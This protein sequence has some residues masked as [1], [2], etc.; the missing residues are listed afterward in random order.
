[1]V[2]TALIQTCIIDPQKTYMIRDSIETSGPQYGMQSFDMALL[3]LLADGS[4]TEE[5]ALAASS[6]PTAL[7][8]KLKGV[9]TP[10]DWRM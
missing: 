8:L 1:M 4:I 3:R 5:T 10:S 7:Q 2:H 9:E 6:N